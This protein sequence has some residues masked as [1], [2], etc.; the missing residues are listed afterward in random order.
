MKFLQLP[1]DA[2]FF[3]R[4]GPLQRGQHERVG[5]IN[6]GLCANGIPI[7]RKRTVN[8]FNWIIFVAFFLLLLLVEHQQ[9]RGK[10]Q[11]DCM[12]HN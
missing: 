5:G 10:V 9:C 3:F 2:V 8:R 12:H 11:L 1:P 6:D 4:W 7:R